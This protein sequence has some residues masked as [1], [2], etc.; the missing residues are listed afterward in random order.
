MDG[1][2]LDRF[3][4]SGEFVLSLC[5]AFDDGDIVGECPLEGCVIGQFKMQAVNVF[6]SAPV[7]TVEFALPIDGV[8]P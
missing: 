6:E 2:G 8:K 5:T 1:L 3:K 4:T 7:A